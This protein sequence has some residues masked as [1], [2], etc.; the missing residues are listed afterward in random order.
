MNANMAV[1]T[2]AMTSP[3][4]ISAPRNLQLLKEREWLDVP[5]AY[6]NGIRAIL[7]I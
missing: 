6:S 2:A 3:A 7:N 1:C 4:A 5:F